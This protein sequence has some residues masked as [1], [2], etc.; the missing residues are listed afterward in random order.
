VTAGKKDPV[1]KC[2]GC[3]AEKFE[4]GSIQTIGKP[5]FRPD[6]IKFMTLKSGLEIAVKACQN[7]GN[8]QMNIDVNELTQLTNE[9]L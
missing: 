7:C 1:Q 5:V 9:K 8:L 2:L 3:G 4:T 6:N